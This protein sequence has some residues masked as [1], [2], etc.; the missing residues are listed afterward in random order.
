MKPTIIVI[1][2]ADIIKLGLIRSFGESGYKIIS[3][4]V[5][6]K[7]IFKMKP[8]DYYSKYVST[9]Y[10][11]K[12]A[13]LIG[14][15]IDKCRDDVQKPILMPLTDN[16]VYLIDQSLSKLS[17][18]FIIPSINGREGGI[19]RLMNK[20]L[21]KKVA[22][23]AGLN[24]PKTWEISFVDGDF[25][26]P[27]DIEYPCF[28][29]GALSYKSKKQYQKKCSCTQELNDLLTLC[30]RAGVFDL[31]AEEYL[32][33]D[34][35]VGVIT[36]SS[37]TECAIPAIVEFLEMGRNPK[38]GISMR[39]QIC[40][41]NNRELIQAI[42]LFLTKT[43]YVGICNLDFIVSRGKYYFVEVNFRYAA[44]GYGIFKS[45]VNVPDMIVCS[46]LGGD[47]GKF[48][49]LPNSNKTFFNEKV[50]LID[51]MDGSIT[52]KKYKEK[53]KQSDI[54]MIAD[55][56]DPKPNKKMWTIV[57]NNIVNKTLSRLKK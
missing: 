19:T 9:Y 54:L 56:L 39:G 21:Q 43:C 23:E 46:L 36:F 22:A 37:Q 2:S 1:G 48:D 33:I 47:L 42:K 13:N 16:M 50:G 15:L 38:G 30:K 10:F 26:I 41:A 51:V 5:S 24:V 57:V 31:C 11:T 55:F 52:F 8:L 32:D 35:E 29:K 17:K 20:V 14:L 27:E 53:R 3:I 7:N 44:Y 25:V 18:Y 28:V 45:G 6:G 40:P 4:H 34:K 12:A 49:T